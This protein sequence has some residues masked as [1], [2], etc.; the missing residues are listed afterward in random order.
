M[1]WLVVFSNNV[2]MSH[3]VPYLDTL[4]CFRLS[5]QVSKALAN[6]IFWPGKQEWE[7]IFQWKQRIF[8]MFFNEDLREHLRQRYDDRSMSAPMVSFL[9]PE[10]MIANVFYNA[11]LKNS[12]CAPNDK[13]LYLCLGGCGYACEPSRFVARRFCKYNCCAPCYLENTSTE[14]MIQ[15]NGG[16]IGVQRVLQYHCDKVHEHVKKSA[17]GLAVAALPNEEDR[18]R[19]EI[20]LLR[21]THGKQFSFYEVGS[22]GMFDKYNGTGFMDTDTMLMGASPTDFVFF[23][24]KYVEGCI[25]YCVQKILWLLKTD[26]CKIVFNANREDPPQLDVILGFKRRRINLN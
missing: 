19:F 3:L 7:A 17:F 8:V 12:S 11:H 4:S 20:F 10:N 16:I 6:V 9:S 22:M 23:S 2:I 15:K 25:E 14:R 13:E 18:H 5:I 21:Q 26:F 24:I 1:N